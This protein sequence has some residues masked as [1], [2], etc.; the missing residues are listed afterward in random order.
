MARTAL[1][2]TLASLA[3]TQ[4]SLIYNFSSVMATSETAIMISDEDSDST[5]EY[6]SVG[7]TLVSS[8]DSDDDRMEE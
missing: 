2:A 3:T 7:S 4:D 6:G 8:D 1:I 5:N